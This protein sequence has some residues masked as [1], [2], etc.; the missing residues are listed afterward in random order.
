M[1]VT[2]ASAEF[3][4]SNMSKANVTPSIMVENQ[5]SNQSDPT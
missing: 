2:K 5:E 4:S 1:M 3:Q